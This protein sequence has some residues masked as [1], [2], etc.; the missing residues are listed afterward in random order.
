MIVAVYLHTFY[1]KVVVVGPFDNEDQCVGF[2]DQQ[3]HPET[4]LLR[5]VHNPDENLEGV[6]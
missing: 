3:K 4:W 5:T 6:I 1:G 2:M